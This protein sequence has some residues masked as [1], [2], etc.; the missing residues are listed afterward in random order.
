MKDYKYDQKYFDTGMVG[1]HADSFGKIA[2]RLESH[3]GA[4]RFKR[5]LDVGCGDGFYGEV[6]KRYTDKLWGMDIAN[7]LDTSDNRTHYESYIQADLESPID[8]TGKFDLIFCSEVIEHIEEYESF[9]SGL[10]AALSPGGLLFLT[11]TTY[12]CYLPIYLTRSPSQ[13]SVKEIC[14]FF[15]GWMGFNSQRKLFVMTLWDWTKGHYHGFSLSRIKSAARKVGFKVETVEYLH[16]QAVIETQVFQNP[17]KSLRCR[18]LI[19]PL[20]RLCG[21]LCKIFNLICGRTDI[22]GR[23]LVLIAT[24]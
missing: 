14:S 12:P 18:W 10:H 23:N 8:S 5:G 17:F 6:L 3:V 4:R 20:L 15:L 19:L 24:K 21:F 2:S 13:W 22:Y 16:A 7:C 1:W 11:T 9:L